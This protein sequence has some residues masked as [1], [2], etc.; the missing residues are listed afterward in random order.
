MAGLLYTIPYATFGLWAGRKTDK[1]NRKLFLGI[2]IILASLTMG[3][4]G[5][6]NSFAV[7][8]LMRVFHG[9]LNSASNPLSF[10]LIADYFPQDKRA[11]ANSIV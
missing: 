11:T 6:V 2:V 7:F 3:V 10:S 9:M 8:A 5:F 4:S 1:V